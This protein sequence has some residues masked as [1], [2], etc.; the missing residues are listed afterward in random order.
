MHP[1]LDLTQRIV[2]TIG[3]IFSHMRSTT[4]T[5]LF[6]DLQY[7]PRH[8]LCF[9]LL[10]LK[11]APLSSLFQDVLPLARVA[12]LHLTTRYL[13]FILV[14]VHVFVFLER[15]ALIICYV[16]PALR[17]HHYGNMCL[18]SPR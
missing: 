8:D 7:S 15:S 13:D 12:M 14:F 4:S 6:Q 3:A 11:P 16:R 17:P 10:S 2:T 5:P 9:Y 1:L 18:M